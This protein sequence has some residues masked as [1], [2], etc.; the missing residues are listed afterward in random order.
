MHIEV[1]PE[2]ED[3]DI[4]LGALQS[5]LDGSKPPVLVSISHVPTSSGWLVL[6]VP[7]LVIRSLSGCLA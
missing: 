1:I 2:T 3:G 5:L 4:D 7:H 6:H